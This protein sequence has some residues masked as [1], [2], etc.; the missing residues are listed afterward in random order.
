VAETE[1]ARGKIV[2]LRA[3]RRGKRFRVVARRGAIQVATLP[4]NGWID[5][6]D[7]KN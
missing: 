3:P 1:I 7:S 2:E 6:S 5:L 4:L